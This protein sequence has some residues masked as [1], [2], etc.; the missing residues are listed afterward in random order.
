MVYNIPNNFAPVPI[1]ANNY[2][3]GGGGIIDGSYV[4]NYGDLAYIDNGIT[5]VGGG[6]IIGCDGGGLSFGGDAGA[7]S[8][9]I[10]GI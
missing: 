1:M 5:C 3:D 9:D 6:D 10:G 4:S 7:C 2:W 8:G